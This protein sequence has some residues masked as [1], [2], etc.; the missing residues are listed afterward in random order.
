MGVRSA[1]TTSLSARAHGTCPCLSPCRG[2][3]R[4]AVGAPGQ[5]LQV[6]ARTE[7]LH[8]QASAIA[9]DQPPSASWRSDLR[10][11]CR[12][13]PCAD[14]GRKRAIR[15]TSALLGSKQR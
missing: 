12:S 4:T 10:L 8:A 2:E 1:L 3:S 9:H 6:A 13:E 15:A 5:P 11:C 7:V 14:L